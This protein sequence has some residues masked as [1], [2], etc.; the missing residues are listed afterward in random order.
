MI[1]LELPARA[2]DTPGASATAHRSDVEITNETDAQFYEVRSPSGATV[3]PRRRL[4]TTLGAAA[5]DLFDKPTDPMG[6]TVTFRARLRYDADYG[7]SSEETSPTN[8]A[9][10]VPGFTRGPVDLMYAYVEGRRFVHGLL[11]WKL[12]RQYVTDALGWWS[13]DGGDVKL[14]T[15][16]YFAVE[17]Y[18]GLE[19]RGGMPLSTPRFE[20]D[21]IW[22]GDR[23]GI[24]RDTWAAFQTNEVAPAVGAAIESAGF[25]W[26]H[27]RLTY[28]RVL[29][30][31][32]SNVSEF[33]NGLRTSGTFE[34]T[35]ISSERIGYAMD[36][37]LP[38]L[39]GVKGG[40]VY[41][42]YVKSVSSIY[43]SLDWYTTPKLTLSVDYDFYK[44]TFDA[45]S[46]WNF[47]LS[48]PMNDLG[49]RAAWDPT[50]HLGLAAGVHARIFTLQTGPDPGLDSSYP[51]S[52][53]G[54]PNYYPSSSLEPTGG[55]N[56]SGRWRFGEGSVG[57]RG[58]ADFA[59]NGERLG[60]DVFGE[61]TLETRYL[62]QARAGVW[63]WNDQLR[64]DRDATD[65]TYV[66]GAGYKLL[67]RS[68]VLAD[69]QHDMNRI[70][71]QRFRVMVHLTIALSN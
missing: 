5:Y 42:M 19:Q 36:G 6:P 55:G 17:A 46:I 49:L 9:R 59:S 69:F 60:L 64:A 32:S 63:Q 8:P 62:L 58:V 30:T 22:R 15:P 41:D 51:T 66:L 21:G 61:R 53:N 70:G 11:G 44:P 31:G 39:G 35:R 20:R 68:L 40:I 16:Y 12:G 56:L 4:T 27:G 24:D 34:G 65:F 54:I 14:T 2:D 29:N 48:M 37:S 43:G 71:G 1:A 23:S 25:T 47:F 7:G 33:Q 3:I 13:F 67:P 52:P 26:L 18:G 50:E 57:A 10:F 28:R 45:D 38:N